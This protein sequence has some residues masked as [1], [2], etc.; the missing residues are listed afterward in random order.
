[1]I[2]ITHIVFAIFFVF[3][4]T[5][6]VFVRAKLPS[7]AREKSSLLMIFTLPFAYSN[8]VFYLTPCHPF[9]YKNAFAY[10][11]LLVWIINL[12]STLTILLFGYSPSA[13]ANIYPI[14]WIKIRNPIFSFLLILFL[15]L[16]LSFSFRHEVYYFY[17]SFH[18]PCSFCP[19]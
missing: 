13:S 5:I 10:T 2:S 6:S 4:V 16:F 8:K 18:C 9:I 3:I 7:F 15:L 19:V 14:Y 1:M 17:R 12:Y 11:P